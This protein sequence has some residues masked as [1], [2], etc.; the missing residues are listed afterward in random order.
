MTERINMLKTVEH[1]YPFRR[2][3]MGAEV[4]SS[5][6]YL[7]GLNKHFK[8]L[9]F[10]SR[11]KAYDWEVPNEWILK[12]ARL[13]HESGK[14]I[15]DTNRNFL[16]VVLYSDAVDEWI[17]KEHLL[18]HLYYSKERPSAIP[19]VTQYYRRHWGFC[20]TKH[21]F[22]TL[23]DGMYH[24]KI[25]SIFKEGELNISHAIIPGTSNKEIF[26]SS[27]ICHPNLANN[28]LSGPA[29]I[30]KLAEYCELLKQRH[31][32]Y[33]FVIAP[34]TIGALCYISKYIQPLKANVIAGYVLSCVGDERAY[35]HIKSPTGKN[36]SDIAL[37][38]SISHKHNAREYSFLV[39]GSDERQYCSPGVDL[40]ICGFSKSKYGEY[41]EYHTSDD[42]L[43]LVSAQGLNESF[44]VMR[45]I[46]DS[47]ECGPI[48]STVCTGE[49]QL[50]KRGLYN[51]GGNVGDRS[52]ETRNIE[53]I[54]AFSNGERSIYEICLLCG[55]T[56]GEGL[57]SINRLTDNKLLQLRHI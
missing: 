35:S 57:K 48:P 38:S 25:H 56:L 30:I 13:T 8:R 53:N 9:S 18:E 3:L 6:D 33:R 36:L 10:P 28:E 19:Y 20:V 7:E 21:S 55:I 32:T 44:E 17:S 16:E 41:P 12:R 24:A 39:R 31:Y 50:G 40:P 45:D 37:R 54:L 15:S 43:E 46:I 42:N 49:P 47:L 1:L 2:C 14:V 26:F 51:S 27:Y 4:R 23:P 22:D 11:Y 34:E 29:L 5:L 52:L